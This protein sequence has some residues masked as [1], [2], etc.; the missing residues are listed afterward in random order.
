MVFVVSW[1]FVFW[2]VIVGVEF[3]F[4]GKVC[5]DIVSFFNSCFLLFEGYVVVVSFFVFRCDSFYN[6]II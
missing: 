5:I 1:D 6:G 2:F 3:V 4:Y